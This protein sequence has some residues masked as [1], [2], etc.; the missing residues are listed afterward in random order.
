MRTRTRRRTPAVAEKP[1]ATPNKHECS[2][3][4]KLLKDEDRRG[5]LM[6]MLR[7]VFGRR[8]L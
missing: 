8:R 1:M 3:S 7:E 4:Y 2:Y 5:S 6:A